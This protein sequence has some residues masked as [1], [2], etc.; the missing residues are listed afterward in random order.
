MPKQPLDCPDFRTLCRVHASLTM[1]QVHIGRP[2]HASGVFRHVSVMF[3][4]LVQIDGMPHT[5]HHIYNAVTKELHV[6]LRVHRIL[7][8][9]LAA[10]TVGAPT[11]NTLPVL[12]ITQATFA[13]VR[14]SMI[15][16]IHHVTLPRL[17]PNSA[18]VLGASMVCQL[19]VGIRLT[20]I[21]S[22]LLS[23]LSLCSSKLQSLCLQM[24][25][26]VN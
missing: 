13:G 9:S 21:L 8:H 7:A 23:V 17:S 15:I 10:C 6:W 20:E 16:K 24:E 25:R 3:L 22:V 11:T 1:G 12:C 2:S 14:I 26:L 4:E 19:V 5:C 18:E